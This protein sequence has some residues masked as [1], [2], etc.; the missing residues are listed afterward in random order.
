MCELETASLE[1]GGDP[2]WAAAGG[3][4]AGAFAADRTIVCF[5][6]DGG[7]ENACGLL[8]PIGLYLMYSRK[9]FPWVENYLQFR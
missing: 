8:V 6:I 5:V 1:L 7:V 4:G 3:D 9:Y 2:Q